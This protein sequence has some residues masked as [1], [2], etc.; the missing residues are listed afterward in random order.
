MGRL[1]AIESHTEEADLSGCFSKEVPQMVRG[2]K[3]KKVRTI[4]QP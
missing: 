3:K 2:H 1:Y 4:A